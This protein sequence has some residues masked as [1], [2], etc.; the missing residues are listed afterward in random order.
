MSVSN[1][2]NTKWVINNTVGSVP[3]PPVRFSVTFISNGNNYTELTLSYAGSDSPIKYDNTI[4]YD[5]GNM[6]WTNQAYRII[7][8]TGGTNVTNASLIEWLLQN[9]TQVNVTD[10]TNTKWQFNDIITLGD[11]NYAIYFVSGVYPTRVYNNLISYLASTGIPPIPAHL[12]YVFGPDSNNQAYAFN[13]WV[14]NLYKTIEISSG[15]D[16]AN[17]DLIVWLT[18]NATLQPNVKTFDLSTL[19][20]SAGT[21]TIQV[22][23]RAQNYRDSNFSNAVSYV[24]APTGY[25]VTIQL[26]SG[27]VGDGGL[28]VYTEQG[29]TLLGTVYPNTPLSVQNVTNLYLDATVQAYSITNIS[30]TLGITAQIDGNGNATAT[31]AAD[32]TIT[33]T[34]IND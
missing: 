25:D 23:A 10:L 33:V 30:T 13:G 2:T 1:L 18:E 16:I 9:A 26:A 28:K 34:M 3:I 31:V 5:Y 19:Q 11:F 14:D 24:V 20:L 32:G 12:D 6:I 27:S 22:R 17:P 21:H 7:E 29:G 4:A 8:I 15:T